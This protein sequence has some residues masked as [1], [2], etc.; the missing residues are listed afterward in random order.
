MGSGPMSNQRWAPQLSARPPAPQ[1]STSDAQ[2]VEDVAQ[3]REPPVVEGGGRAGRPP[4]PS[5]SHES[6]CAEQLALPLPHGAPQVD[7]PEGQDDRGGH[8]QGPVEP[9]AQLAPPGRPSWHQSVARDGL[10]TGSAARGW[11]TSPARR[12]RAGPRTALGDLDRPPAPR[13]RRRGRRARSARRRR[14]AGSRPGRSRR[15]RRGRPSAAGPRCR[16]AAGGSTNSS[17]RCRSCPPP[18]PGRAGAVGGA[19]G[20]R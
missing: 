19:L 11:R 2:A 17:G 6:C 1:T 9:G 13:P 12:R 5:A 20:A 8:G 15:T 3:A 16:R 10:S 18:R 4:T 7:Q 14:S